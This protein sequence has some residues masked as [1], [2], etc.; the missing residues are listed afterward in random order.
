MTEQKRRI[1]KA[2]E[3]GAIFNT[4]N[5]LY[6]STWGHMGNKLC[7]AY[8]DHPDKARLLSR[9]DWEKTSFCRREQ[10]QF[11]AHTPVN[12]VTESRS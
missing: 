3:R 5:H 8:C 1:L 12:A 11:H 10:F 2:E 7:V 9:G 6:V 4:N